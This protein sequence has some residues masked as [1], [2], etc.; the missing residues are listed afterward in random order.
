[1]IK[2]EFGSEK[3]LNLLP[4]K[5]ITT[6]IKFIELQITTSQLRLGDGVAS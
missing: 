1:M 2:T 4:Q 3:Y 5:F 6:F